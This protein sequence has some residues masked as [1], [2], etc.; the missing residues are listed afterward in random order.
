MKASEVMSYLG[1]SRATLKA[2]AKQ[3]KIKVKEKP[4][5]NLVIYDDDSVYALRGEKAPE[6]LTISYS[7]VQKEKN[8]DLLRQQTNRIF[9]ACVLRGIQID[10]QFQEVGSALVGDRPQLNRILDL[11]LQR[12]IGTIVVES[13]DRLSRFG[14]EVIEKICALCGAKIV[15]LSEKLSNTAYERELMDDI[16]KTVNTLSDSPCYS[17]GKKTK[18]NRIIGELVELDT[19]M[20]N[21][22]D[23]LPDEEKTKFVA[24][25][26]LPQMSALESMI[27]NF[28]S[29]LADLKLQQDKIIGE[30]DSDG[31]LGLLEADPKK[32]YRHIEEALNTGLEILAN[33]KMLIESAPDADGL[34]AAASVM[35]AVQS[36]FREFTSVWQKQM[37]FQNM[38]NLEAVKLQNKK[39]LESHRMKLKLDYFN[40][41]NTAAEVGESG[42]EKVPF[43]TK[44]FINAFNEE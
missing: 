42:S 34:S 22:F 21:D 40:A 38:I 9:E 20:D 35:S 18:L 6:K 2:Y 24:N 10:K 29:K 14:F 44:D 28:Q 13:K 16:V 23:Y 39:E 17:V 43:N 4:A 33:A 41:T 5:P 7:R 12:K 37:Y 30:S 31:T 32:T 27:G 15:V 26:K 8:R 25:N 11:V 3:G 36:L 1:I 19:R